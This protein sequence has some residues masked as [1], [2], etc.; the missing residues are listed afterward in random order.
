MSRKSLP[1]K[2][3]PPPFSLPNIVETLFWHPRHSAEPAHSW[4]RQLLA[5]EAAEDQD[6]SGPSRTESV[7]SDALVGVAAH[8]GNLALLPK[9]GTGNWSSCRAVPQ[10]L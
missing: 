2:L 7:Q 5:E 8:K 6:E 4:L 10:R 3:L 1:I 9:K